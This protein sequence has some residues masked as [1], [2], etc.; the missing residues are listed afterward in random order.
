MVR[1]KE[2]KENCSNVSNSMLAD[3]KRQV[4]EKIKTTILVIDQNSSGVKLRYMVSLYINPDAQTI[5]NKCT[6]MQ[7]KMQC[8]RMMP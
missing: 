5:P 6:A 2:E 3:E 1:K 7:R 8:R 4:Q